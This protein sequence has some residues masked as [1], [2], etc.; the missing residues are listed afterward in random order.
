MSSCLLAGMNLSWLGFRWTS[1]V[2]LEW[3][4]IESVL[5]GES[6]QDGSITTTRK[7]LPAAVEQ[8]RSCRNAFLVSTCSY[9]GTARHEP[10]HR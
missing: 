6:S 1:V 8:A 10:A 4:S 7:G 2:M 5:H 9:S 3:E